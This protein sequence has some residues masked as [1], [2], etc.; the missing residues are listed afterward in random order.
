MSNIRTCEYDKER[1]FYDIYLHC[2]GC[3]RTDTIKSYFKCDV[4]TIGSPSD[5]YS[6]RRVGCKKCRNDMFMYFY[7]EPQRSDID[8][9]WGGPDANPYRIDMEVKNID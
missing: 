9:C 3:K 7:C 6:M 4:G 2:E 8:R 5:Y 1:H